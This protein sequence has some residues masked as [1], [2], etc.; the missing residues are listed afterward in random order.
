MA[1][2]CRALR[3]PC[4][5]AVACTFTVACTFAVHAV[6]QIQKADVRVGTSAFSAF[7]DYVVGYAE[8]EVEGVFFAAV[9]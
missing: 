9:D 7:F 1:L 2:F 3:S 6:S 4:T 5:F 8:G